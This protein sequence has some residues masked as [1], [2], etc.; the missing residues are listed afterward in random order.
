MRRPGI[1]GLCGALLLALAAGDV[2]A[3]EADVVSAGG[4]IT[5]IVFALGEQDRLVARDTT[6]TYP[7]AA[8]ALPNVGYLRAL[9]PEGVLA[10]RPGL[11]LAEEDAGPPETLE[12]LRAAGVPLVL[13]PD[14]PSPEGITAKIRAVGDALGAPERADQLARQVT[15]QMRAVAGRAAGLADHARKRVLFV[16][17]LQGGRVLAAG[18]ETKAASVIELAGAVNAMAGF[19]GYKPVTEEAII[20]AAPDIILMMDR[21][22]AQPVDDAAVLAMPAIAATPAGRNKAVIRMDGQYLLGFGPRT[23]RAV[24]DLAT[25]IYGPAG[26]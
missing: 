23:A 21:G 8:R 15:D 24:T 19:T 4:S 5:E 12:V 2:R 7:D 10:L 1:A 22:G 3:G 13:I 16:L 20:A 14:D 25:R 11:I 17:S 26:S 6:S 18:E 9:S